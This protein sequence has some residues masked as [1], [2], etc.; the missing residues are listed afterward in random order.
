MQNDGQLTAEQREQI[1][2]EAR[3]SDAEVDDIVEQ[4]RKA[5]DGSA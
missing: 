3:E 4:A 2:R 5:A 1:E